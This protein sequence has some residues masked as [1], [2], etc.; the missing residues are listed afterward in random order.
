MLDK[1]EGVEGIA[2]RAVRAGDRVDVVVVRIARFGEKYCGLCKSAPLISKKIDS[3]GNARIQEILISLQA[4]CV[5]A[6]AR[7]QIVTDSKVDPVI[8][9]VENEVCFR[10]RNVFLGVVMVLWR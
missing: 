4:L 6:L 10:R 3:F 9:V 7:P 5:D 8:P 1:G 2:E